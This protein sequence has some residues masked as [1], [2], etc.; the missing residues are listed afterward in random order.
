VIRL[1]INFL[2]S[3]HATVMTMVSTL[4]LHIMVFSLFFQLGGI[5]YVIIYWFQHGN[6]H[7]VIIFSI[8]D[9]AQPGNCSCMLKT[10]R[11]E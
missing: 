5:F 9:L 8:I 2:C 6:Y 10:F 7:C 1:S 4:Y 3:D 11:K